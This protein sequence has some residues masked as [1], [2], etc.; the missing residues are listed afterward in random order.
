MKSTNGRARCILVRQGTLS[1]ERRTKW[2]AM[3][4]VQPKTKASASSVSG[5]IPWS[6]SLLRK[7]PAK[8]APGMVIPLQSTSRMSRKLSQS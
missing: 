2:A 8:Q 4:H 1:L 6:Q 3:R 7:P 5:A